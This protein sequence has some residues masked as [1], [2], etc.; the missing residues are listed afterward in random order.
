MTV[1]I[2]TFSTYF[3]VYLTFEHFDKTIC[4]DSTN[5]NRTIYIL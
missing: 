3:P 5:Y 2:N 4:N 1:N